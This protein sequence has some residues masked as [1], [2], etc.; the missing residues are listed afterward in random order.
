MIILFFFLQ[1]KITFKVYINGKN[2]Y[3][4]DDQN[5]QVFGCPWKQA[6]WESTKE[7]TSHGIYGNKFIDKKQQSVTFHIN[8]AVPLFP[9]LL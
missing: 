7:K 9:F 8:F 3:L 6:S 2:G 1:T 5:S 4:W